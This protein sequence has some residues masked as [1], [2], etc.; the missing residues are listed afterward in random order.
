MTGG[1]G[2]GGGGGHIALTDSQHGQAHSHSSSI[3]ISP[4]RASSNGTAAAVAERH[5]QRHAQWDDEESARQQ[6][7]RRT[8]APHSGEHR[9]AA[10][11]SP[12][13]SRH[14]QGPGGSTRGVN[15]EGA[16]GR[17]GSMQGSSS[18]AAVSP[19][20]VSV[21]SSPLRSHGGGGP[22]QAET[23]L[24]GS[25]NSLSEQLAAAEVEKAALRA[26]ADESAAIFQEEQRWVLPPTCNSVVWRLSTPSPSGN[27]CRFRHRQC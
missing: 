4:T 23:A 3:S 6:Q 2:G 21:E 17:Q 5:R 10:W 9:Q 1:G 18:H 27:C 25:I 19:S 12:G 15:W 24:I 13:S 8:P 11:H 7:A 16:G 14:S 26:A 20:R 22:S